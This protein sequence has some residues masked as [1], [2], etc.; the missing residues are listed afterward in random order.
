MRPPRR[1]RSQTYGAPHTYYKL[2]LTLALTLAGRSNPSL[3]NRLRRRRESC[4]ATRRRESVARR[5]DFDRAFLAAHT[6]KNIA[7]ER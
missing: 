1:G 5:S 2:A 3:A 4:R 7:C 6:D